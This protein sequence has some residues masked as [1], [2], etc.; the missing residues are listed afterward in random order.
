VIAFADDL[1]VLTRGAC[2][3]E[4]ENYVNQG[5]K[6]IERR[7]TDNKIELNN[8]KSK[9]LFI[10]RKRNKHRKVN[11]YLNYKRLEQN[12]EIKYLGI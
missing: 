8:K 12:G 9:V 11:I 3:I 5:L 7:A 4:T 6:K 1:I 10:P 2:K